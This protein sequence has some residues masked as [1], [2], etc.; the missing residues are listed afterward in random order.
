MR[1]FNIVLE[2]SKSQISYFDEKH[3]QVIVP[4]I[5]TSRE[6]CHVLDRMTGAHKCMSAERFIQFNVSLF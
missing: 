5:S 1:K 2:P 6:N 3:E 4:I